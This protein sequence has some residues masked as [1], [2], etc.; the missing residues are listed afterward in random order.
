[1]VIISNSLSKRADEGCVKVA[2]SLVK[3]LKAKD[4]NTYVVSF[5]RESDLSDKHL[6][7]NKLLINKKLKHLIR[8]KRERVLY[9]PFPAKPIATALRIFTL[10]RY[11][12]KNLDVIISMQTKEDLISRF[13]LKLSGANF[14]ML[15]RDSYERFKHMVGEKRVTYLKTGIDTEKFVPVSLEKQNSLKKKY[16]FD[17]EKPVILHVGHLNRGRNL[18]VLTKI[19]KKYQVLI[20]VS[21]L[22]E[23]EWDENLR[24]ELL[25]CPNIKIFDT[26]MPNIEELYAMCDAY[27]FP[28]IE[29]GRCIDVPLSCLEAAACNKPVITTQYGEIK[30]L[31]GKNGFFYLDSFTPDAINSIIARAINDDSVNTRDAVLEYD[32]NSSICTIEH[33]FGESK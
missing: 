11:S 27:F 12:K 18:G 9:L 5:E 23:G 3:R 10:S 14:F 4:G 28:V 30:E 29:Y 22:T 7:L 17:A 32:W 21:T 1:M 20:V 31:M 24:E 13:I 19:S 8:E 2:A 26:Y 25:S 6:E 16:G 15:S 33:K